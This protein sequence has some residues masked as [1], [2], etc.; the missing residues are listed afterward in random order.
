LEGFNGKSAL[1]GG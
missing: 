1:V